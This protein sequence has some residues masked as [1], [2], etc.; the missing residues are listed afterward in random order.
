MST[1]AS[2]GDCHIEL[3]SLSRYVFELPNDEA[4]LLPIASCVVVK[5]ASDSPKP[6]NGK[7]DKPIIRPYTPISPSDQEGEFTFLI[8]RYDEG[9]M[10]QHIHSLQPGEKLA[11]KGPIPK[12]SFEGAHIPLA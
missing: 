9:K 8:K 6:L 10:S 1:H 5:S 4:S 12:I 2:Q 11:I 7:N 3:P